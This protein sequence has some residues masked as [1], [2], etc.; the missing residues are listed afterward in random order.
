MV[1]TQSQKRSTAPPSSSFPGTL[2]LTGS[3][4]CALEV[5]GGSM[6]ALAGR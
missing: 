2:L 4:F 5:E 3:E 6:G 1:P